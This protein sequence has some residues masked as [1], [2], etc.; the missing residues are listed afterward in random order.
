MMKKILMC[1]ML[2]FMAANTCDAQCKNP[3]R[4]GV[5]L[6]AR[7]PRDVVKGVGGYFMDV[8]S[9]AANGVGM[10]ITAPFKAK[11]HFPKRKSYFYQPPVW[12]P[13]KLT[14]IPEPKIPKEPRLY[15][16]LYIGPPVDDGLIV[17]LRW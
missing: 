17:M 16:P 12:T 3:K 4:K 14:P 5:V 2:L 1:L 6:Q 9:R 11:C 13:G 8:G 7:S 10:V 15:H